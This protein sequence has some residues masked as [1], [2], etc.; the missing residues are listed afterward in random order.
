MPWWKRSAH[1]HH[2]SS[3]STPASPA[4]ASTSRIPRRD[5]GDLGGPPDHQPRL[6]RARRLRHV[7]DIEVGVSALRMDDSPTAAPSSSPGGTRSGLGS[8]PPALRRS[9]G[10]RAT[11]RWCLRGRRPRPCCCPALRRRPTRMTRWAE[12]LGGRSPLRGCS[13]GIA[14]ARM[15]SRGLRRQEVKGRRRFQGDGLFFV[16]SILLKLV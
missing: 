11:W 14:T 16:C 4:R 2:S 9:R 13:T 7:D 6:T 1:H 5:G 10:R 15:I 12:A 8:P 3:A